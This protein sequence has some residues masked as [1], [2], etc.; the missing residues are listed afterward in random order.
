MAKLRIT[1]I[2][3]VRPARGPVPVFNQDADSGQSLEY[4]ARL[5]LYRSKDWRVLRDRQKRLA[6][7]SP[8]CKKCGGPASI[9]DHFLGHEDSQAAQ[10]AEMLGIPAADRW[11][12]RFFRG[13]FIWLCSDCHNAKTQVEMNGRLIE[14]INEIGV[15]RLQNK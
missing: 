8:V 5:A 10:I 14:W 9:L 3:K 13:P 6:G 11:R 12:A 2:S 4:Q 7:G 15:N 1:K